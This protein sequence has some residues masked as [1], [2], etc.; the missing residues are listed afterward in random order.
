MTPA[1]DAAIENAAELRRHR[2]R[3]RSRLDAARAELPR[4]LR[5]D[6]RE[7]ARWWRA[8]ARRVLRAVTR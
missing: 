6:A 3:E 1:D 5:E 8:L 2:E 7:Q 4:T